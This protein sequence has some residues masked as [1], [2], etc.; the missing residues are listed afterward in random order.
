MFLVTENPENDQFVILFNF[1]ILIEMEETY[2]LNYGVSLSLICSYENITYVWVKN[3]NKT[4]IEDLQ[5]TKDLM[6]FVKKNAG[7]DKVVTIQGS[8]DPEDAFLQPE[9]PPRRR[10][11][12]GL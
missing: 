7:F 12:R 1:S 11:L 5:L 10:V 9:T 4:T 6:S 8:M 2:S 3:W